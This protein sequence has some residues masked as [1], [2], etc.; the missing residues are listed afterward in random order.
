MRG[1]HGGRSG[2]RSVRRVGVEAVRRVPAVD[3][4]DGVID[5]C[6]DKTQVEKRFGRELGVSLP[7]VLTASAFYSEITLGS[8]IA[9]EAAAAAVPVVRVSRSSVV[10]LAATARQVW[11]L[12]GGEDKRCLLNASKFGPPALGCS[13]Q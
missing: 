8:S 9:V 7:S 10:A 2:G 5:G 6:L 3:T 12:R 1:G 11:R 4:D 13:P